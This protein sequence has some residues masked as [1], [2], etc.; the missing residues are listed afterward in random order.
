MNHKTTRSLSLWMAV[1]LLQEPVSAA[2]RQSLRPSNYPTPSAINTMLAS[3]AQPVHKTKKRS[4]KGLL[5]KL[6]SAF[7]GSKTSSGQ[8][9]D[10]AGSAKKQTAKPAAKASA[11]ASK[12][13][14]IEEPSVSGASAADQA[15]GEHI[16][17]ITLGRNPHG[18]VPIASA[19]VMKQPLP[20]LQP[21]QPF[22]EEQ[23]PA[24]Q[25]PARTARIARTTESPAAERHHS[26]PAV[27]G[28]RG[29]YHQVAQGEDLFAVA[30]RYGV[31]EE[32]ILR[33][34]PVP[35]QGPLTAGKKVYVPPA[36]A[37][38]MF[39]PDGPVVRTAEM[40]EP[41]TYRPATPSKVASLAPVRSTQSTVS[42]T[43]RPA[44]KAGKD[45]EDAWDSIK[46]TVSG[47]FDN[48][49]KF[50]GKSTRK[51]TKPQPAP[52][53]ATADADEAEV[54]AAV[55][56]PSSTRA[57]A[58]TAEKPLFA[59]PVS[60]NVI[61]Q[62]GP[63]HG[64]PHNGV[65]VS[66]SR[67]TPVQAAAAGKV[68]FSSTMRG[69]GNVVIL[70]HGNRYFTVYAHNQQNLVKRTPDTH[71]TSVKAGQTIALVGQTGNAQS[72]HVHFEVRLENKAIDPLPF[73]PAAAG[74]P[75]LQARA[76][77]LGLESPS[78]KSGL[79]PGNL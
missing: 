72:P 45:D 32:D 58:R 34:N 36:G 15:R 13:E 11:T 2:G 44:A 33:Y 63:R 39:T 40:A 7:D 52:A 69:Y 37:R 53:D 56:A 29:G 68:I 38:L 18:S 76:G 25:A 35:A 64:V 70:D 27:T 57:T 51:S 67:G 28:W 71:P 73:L 43:A 62:Y 42:R 77:G 78:S 16:A 20:E 12:L 26:A 41:E 3:P 5:A 66:A 24:E 23:A 6:S 14:L 49:K 4:L 60:G 9:K 46:N 47:L 50:V 22:E 21:L 79:A 48:I 54:A 17:T 8:K 59:W 55:A 30:D 74:Q 31:K 65:D 10:K 61:S 1:L 19:P 75:E